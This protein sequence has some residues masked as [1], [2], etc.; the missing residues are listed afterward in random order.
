MA[1]SDC[2][3]ARSEVGVLRDVDGWRL[4]T[5][6]GMARDSLIFRYLIENAQIAQLGA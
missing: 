5:G 2:V 3:R 6:K 4:K 1:K